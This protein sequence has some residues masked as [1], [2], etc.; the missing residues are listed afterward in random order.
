MRIRRLFSFV[1][2]L[3][4]MLSMSMVA[5]AAKKV[6]LPRVVDLYEE[7]DME[8]TEFAATLYAGQ[9]IEVGKLY[10]ECLDED[11]YLITYKLKT[12][13]YYFKE[14]HFEAIS[15]GA[16]GFAEDSSLI[17]SGGGI[18]PG[19]LTVNECFDAPTIDE[20]TGAISGTDEYSFIYTAGA[21]VDSFAAHSVVCKVTV[22]TY[23]EI[24]PG[25]KSED[26]FFASEAIPDQ[27]IVE[28]REPFGYDDPAVD[29]PSV[30]DDAFAASPVWNSKLIDS[31]ARFVWNYELSSGLTG[32][33]VPTSNDLT[34]QG[35]VC[36][37]DF[38]VEVP[39]DATDIDATLYIV[40][41]NGYIAKIGD[42]L[43]SSAGI[44]PFA[45]ADLT[46]DELDN[47]FT[48]PDL[49]LLYI[50]DDLTPYD[51]KPLFVE[52]VVP[53]NAWNSMIAVGSDVPLVPGDNTVEIKAVNEQMDGGNDS[54]NPAGVIFFIEYSW[55]VPT[56]TMVTHYSLV[57]AGCETA[58]GFGEDA[59]GNNW[60][61]IIE[62]DFDEPGTPV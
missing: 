51:T 26:G 30:W 47:A 41:D 34:T 50:F 33:P 25:T 4:L 17:Y 11:E 21:E 45:Y 36:A 7:T 13:G 12:E 52:S 62:N 42:T 15:D 60:S 3:V 5:M 57:P 9:N 53:S 14:V 37:I 20:F 28:V 2:A 1:M 8:A 55:T 39:D 54:N 48:D 23:D 31:G 35:A 29:Q 10:I 24:I 19:K 32:T 56:T 58:W 16:A 6:T 59:D 40:A 44:N 18:I 43:I 49:L 46:D 27:G 22:D 38:D 61:Q